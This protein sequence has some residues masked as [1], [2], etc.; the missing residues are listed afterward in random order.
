MGM[1]CLTSKL[2]RRSFVGSTT[3]F[4]TAL[5]ASLISHISQGSLTLGR[6]RLAV[7]CQIACHQFYDSMMQSG[8]A[9]MRQNVFFPFAHIDLVLHEHHVCGPH[10]HHRRQSRTPSRRA[11][12][13]HPKCVPKI[14]TNLP[15]YLWEKSPKLSCGTIISVAKDDRVVV[16]SRDS[17]LCRE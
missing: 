17:T 1:L 13:C 7:S 6:N 5:G 2:R 8:L 14:R 11:N 9:R 3:R 10:H 12:M 15:P 16:A 4:F